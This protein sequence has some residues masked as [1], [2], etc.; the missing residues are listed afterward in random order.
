MVGRRA[1]GRRAKVFE[2]SRTGRAVLEPRSVCLNNEI[3]IEASKLGV[4]CK[5]AYEERNFTR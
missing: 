5:I 2:G 3:L 1:I 4:R